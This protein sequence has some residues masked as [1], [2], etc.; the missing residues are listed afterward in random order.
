MVLIMMMKI[1]LSVL[2]MT[3]TAVK[4]VPLES[5]IKIMMAG[6]MIVMVPVTQKM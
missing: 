4:T 5:M 2:I 3:V 1:N 6:T